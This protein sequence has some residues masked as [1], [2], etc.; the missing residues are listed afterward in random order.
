[1]L[2]VMDLNDWLNDRI[3]DCKKS[4]TEIDCRYNYGTHIKIVGERDAYQN[5]LNHLVKY[6]KD[7]GGSKQNG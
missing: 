5:V 7:N 4:I 1:M 6:G 2:L 3:N